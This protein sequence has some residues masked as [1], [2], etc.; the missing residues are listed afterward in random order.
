MHKK[1]YLATTVV[2]TLFGA[3]FACGYVPTPLEKTVVSLDQVA[4]NDNTGVPFLSPGN[5]TRVNLMLLMADAPEA[6][7]TLPNGKEDGARDPIFL[8]AA[9][10]V[11]TPVDDRRAATLSGDPDYDPA[12][13]F[14][15]EASRCVSME[16][17]RRAFIA[18]VIAETAL[19]ET[20]RTELVAARARLAEK[21]TDQTQYNAEAHAYIRPP[22]TAPAAD[23]GD[24][25]SAAALDFKRYL[26]AA[27]AFYDGRFDA[28]LPDFRA[29]T[30]AKNAWLS[31]AATYMIA[32]THLNVA[33]SQ[34]F[35]ADD[36]D[37]EKVDRSSLDA[38]RAGFDS[39][40]A[41]YPQGAYVA[42]AGGLLRRIA[43]LKRDRAALDGYYADMLAHPANSNL[44]VADIASEIDSK[45]MSGAFNLEGVSQSPIYAAAEVLRGMRVQRPDSE[46]KPRPFPLE[47]ARAT[48]EKQPA[49]YAYLKAA[50]H[51]YVR[52]DPVATLADL[53]AAPKTDAK[54]SVGFSLDILRGQA[55]IALEKYPEAEA[56]FRTMQAGALRPWQN[57]AIDLGLATTWE[58]AGQVSKIFES[59]PRIQSPQ[60]R[61]IM[62]ANIAGPIL[63]RQAVADASAPEAE[64]GHTLFTLLFKEITRRQPIGFLK[65]FDPERGTPFAFD[66][67]IKEVNKVALFSGDGS[68]DFYACPDMRHVAQLLADNPKSAKGQL[69]LAGFVQKNE[70]DGF[71]NNNLPKG[72]LGTGKSIFP[73]EPY[74]RHAAYRALIED[75]ATPGRERAHALYKIVKCYASS[76]RNHCNAPDAPKEQRKAWHEELKS[77]YPHSPE[78]K[79]LKYYW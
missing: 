44:G 8:D 31:E 24:Q 22:L 61:G 69:C 6:K 9:L 46:D 56:H 73:G 1:F 14:N 53:D 33:Q 51:Y 28:A 58:R 54:T 40:M 75:P 71:D 36:I 78:A 3:A 27:Y 26:D 19:A 72:S 41:R 65:D 16:T 35:T 68:D 74:S 38:A 20:E 7:T 29:L 76:G 10:T 37:M 77:R 30:N 79:A 18:A 49:L 48:L 52:K 32:R 12:T 50:E 15:R 34:V 47:A 70:L 60:I 39:Y 43:W 17:G 66:G 45:I 25:A 5:D 67:A 42:S 63:L 11:L 4:L 59:Q 55:L 13:A 57:A 62:L 21:C 23:L 64:R 2:L